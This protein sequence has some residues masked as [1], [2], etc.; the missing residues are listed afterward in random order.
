M[1]LETAAQEMVTRFRAS[2]ARPMHELTVAEARRQLTASRR[3]P[4]T[5]PPAAF[6]DNRRASSETGLPLDTRILTPDGDPSAVIVYLHG[7]GWVLGGLD[8]YELLAW[9]LARRAGAIVA[10][11]DYPL[12]PEYP[13][14]AALGLS[15]E[16]VRW[17][18]R[19][20]AELAGRQ[21]P[22]VLFG[23]S[24]GANL[25]AAICHRLRDEPTV[26]VDLQVLAYPPTDAAMD[27]ASYLD[28]DNQLLLTAADMAW[29]WDLYQP[30]AR[31]RSDPAMSV[32][33]AADLGG[34]P[35]TVLLTAEHD[36]LRDEGEAYAERLRQAGVS[37]VSVRWPGTMHGFL[38]YVQ[39]LA[40]SDRA[41]QW[42][43][44][45]I[46]AIAGVPR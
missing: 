1:T 15:C 35:A 44:D 31:L 3:T 13:Y 2:G 29:F 39:V 37:V 10:M 14:P 7:G 41:V 43:A 12:A 18:S 25:A 19:R 42:L 24:A 20:R 40:S 8:D 38:S 46:R 16:T 9:E 27:T 21:V 34:M 32:L 5:P 26:R 11:V 28:P 30:D 45:Q 6:V 33:R 17:F 36:V 4:A 23:D 22:L